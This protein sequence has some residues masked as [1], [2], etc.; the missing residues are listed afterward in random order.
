[1]SVKSSSVERQMGFWSIVLFGVNGILGSGIFLLPG[2]GYN[3][4]GPASI[5]ALLADAVLVF[6]I[7]LC[8]AECAG[9]FK[10]TGGAYLYAKKAFG[11]F[12]GY[13]VGVVTWAI[14]IIA[15]G[16]LYV[17]IAT[18]IGGVYKPWAT[19][20]AKNIIVTIIGI[21]LICIN[22][23]GVK[24]SAIFNNVV[25]VDKLVP[26]LLVAIVG[27][28]FLHPANF[29]PFFLPGSSANGFAN[30]TITLF[31]VFT[32]IESLVITAGNMKDASKNLP[33]ALLLVIIAVALIYVLVVVSCVGILGSGL[34]KSSV[35]L[36]DAAQAVAGRAGEAV[37]I[38]GTFLS[39]GGLALNSSFI[40]PRLAASLADNHQMP[41]KLG[42]ENSKGAPYVAIV[43][44]T[45]LAMAIAWSGSYLTLVNISVVSR[46]AQYIPTCIAVMVFRKTM[47]DKKSSF[48]IPG[49]WII[50]ILAVIVSV[51]LLAHAKPFQL[52]AGFGALFI[53]LPFYFITGQNKRDKARK[54]QG[55]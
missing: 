20:T 37:I 49:G 6:M 31:M 33:R 55:E 48:T 29:T 19:T 22:M 30:A 32:G 14:R 16:T 25:T 8:F 28:F 1:M 51:W 53:I 34:A 13:E 41:K 47:K 15:E 39:M 4:F 36:Q 7:G 42:A 10:E 44:H 9:R 50:P 11:P 45:L 24:T 12:I 27:L 52:I 23:T 40:S 43:I 35:P 3:L 5:L 46:F 26:I 21:I 18:A 17:A 54:E 2:Q 38:V